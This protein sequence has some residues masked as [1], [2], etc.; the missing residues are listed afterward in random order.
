MLAPH[1]AVR[2]VQKLDW[3]RRARRPIQGRQSVFRRSGPVQ[4]AGTQRL[5]SVLSALDGGG[6]PVHPLDCADPAAIARRGE[7]FQ[8]DPTR[9]AAGLAH[10]AGA[11][12]EGVRNLRAGL[13]R[14]RRPRQAGRLPADGS[15]QGARRGGARHR[16][17][18]AGMDRCRAVA[19]RC[20]YRF[21]DVGHQAPR[22]PAVQ[23]SRP[24]RRALS[25]PRCAG[26]QAAALAGVR[27]RRGG[28][29]LCRSGLRDRRADRSRAED[30]GAHM[31]RLAG[32]L[33]RPCQR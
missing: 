17:L 32:P 16:G 28:P 26:R 21:P 2:L 6:D 22:P 8:R 1:P 15:R 19:R 27:A 10:A 11:E 9:R 23:P 31:D 25:F 4:N 5:R 14:Q 20:R 3:S 13:A 12:A 30:H 7:R 24:F 33:R 29:L 18:G